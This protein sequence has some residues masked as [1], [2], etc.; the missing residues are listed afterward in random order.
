VLFVCADADGFPPSSA[1]EFYAL[2]GGGE[3]DAGWDGSAR[4]E[5]QLAILAGRTHYDV[6]AAPELAD[7]VD[8]FL[9]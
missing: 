1:A 3:R 2:L 4:P 5:S 6:V 8:R 7:V 9:A